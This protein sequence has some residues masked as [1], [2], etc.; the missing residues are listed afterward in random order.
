MKCKYFKY[1]DKTKQNKKKKNPKVI[2]KLKTVPRSFFKTRDRRMIFFCCCFFGQM[3]D[4]KPPL[5]NYFFKNSEFRVT[6]LNFAKICQK[7]SENF[8]ILRE[9]NSKHRVKKSLNGE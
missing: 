2:K 3:Q 6:I 8:Q 5:K 9:K 7:S 1:A 4:Y